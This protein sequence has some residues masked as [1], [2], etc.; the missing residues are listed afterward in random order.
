MMTA[1]ASVLNVAVVGAGKVGS[2]LAVAL[3]ECGGYRISGVASRSLESARRLG[4]LVK[5]PA[6]NDPLDVVR[7]ADV[8][9]ITTPDRE[10]RPAADEIARRG[11][12]CPGQVVAHTS[13]ALTSEELSAAREGGAD[14]VSIHPLQSFA[15]TENGASR[16]EGVYFAVEGDAGALPTADRI[17]NDLGGIL[18]HLRGED[19]ALYH[20]AACVAS[21]YLVALIHL[22]TGLLERCGLDRE[23][24]LKALVP[25]LDGTLQNIKE[26]GAV[27]A[28]TGPVAR[29]DVPTLQWHL[30][31]FAR[32][33][34]E[35]GE[36]YRRLGLYALQV[37]REK[38]SVESARAAAIERLLEGVEHN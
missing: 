28:L 30:D 38:G 35:A 5:A 23:H 8:V 19:K 7:S 1:R 27:D 12:F 15:N 11:G 22:A 3:D 25:L 31:A 14:V 2:A 20:A 18:L 17:V 10:I 21:N 33:D 26:L 34:A 24:G 9:F 37:A 13:G 36:L 16:L 29:G 6:S 4:E 32:R